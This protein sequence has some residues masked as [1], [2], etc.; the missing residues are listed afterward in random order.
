MSKKREMVFNDLKIDKLFVATRDYL[1]RDKYDNIVTIKK[2]ELVEILDIKNEDNIIIGNDDNCTCVDMH[3]LNKY[4]KF[5]KVVNHK[6]M[7]IHPQHDD[8][9]IAIRNK[10]AVIV[11]LET[12]FKSVAVC[13]EHDMFDLGIGYRI[14]YYKA[15]I[16]ESMHSYRAEK[17]EATYAIKKAQ[18]S[19]ANVEAKYEKQRKQYYHFLDKAVYQVQDTN[20]DMP[21]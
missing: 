21:F 16:K 8:V 20:T 7:V 9:K 12:G 11:I 19:L 18:E 3:R 6:N 14:A 10:R 13:D 15:K 2:G 5:K 1:S 17:A 4:F